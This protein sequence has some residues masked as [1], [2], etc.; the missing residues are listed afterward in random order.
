MVKMSQKLIRVLMAENANEWNVEC[1]NEYREY[2]KHNL[3]Y[4]KNYKN[5]K[6]NMNFQRY[7]DKYMFEEV[8]HK[9]FKTI[10]DYYKVYPLRYHN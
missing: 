3:Q 7:H 5:I 2:R 1:E 8:W 10:E 9:W 6:L 4:E